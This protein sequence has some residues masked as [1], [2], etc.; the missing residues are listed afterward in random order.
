M[1]RHAQDAS[2]DGPMSSLACNGML[3]ISLVPRLVA[4]QADCTIYQDPG[5]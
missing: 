5:Y 4:A 3:T 2:Y 1:D